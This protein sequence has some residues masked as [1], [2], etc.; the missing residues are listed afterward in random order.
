MI[1]RIC[2]TIIIICCFIL[3]YNTLSYGQSEIS[4]QEAKDFIA[5]YFSSLK[6]GDTEQLLSMLTGAYKK[7]RQNLLKN[8]QYS[9][10][11]RNINADLTFEIV[12]MNVINGSKMAVNII[13][14]RQESIEKLKLI[15][16]SENNILKI[17]DEQVVP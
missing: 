15:L 13:I 14:T 2:A 4:E 17:Y 8:T 7:E 5:H 9:D 16:I 12:D 10:F 6:N 11:L 3:S 1:K